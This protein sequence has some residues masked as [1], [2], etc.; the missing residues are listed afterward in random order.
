M[1][2]PAEQ[3]LLTDQRLTLI[4]CLPSDF[5]YLDDYQQHVVSQIQWDNEHPW[6]IR[7]KP[8]K[9]HMLDGILEESQELIH[10][11]DKVEPDYKRFGALLLLDELNGPAY[12]PGKVTPT[13]VKRHL[14]EFGDVAWYTANYLE[15]FGIKYAATIE[16]GLLDWQLKRA[17]SAATRGNDAHS[18]E[19]ERRVPAI[20]LMHHLNRLKVAA[21]RI[22]AMRRDERGLAEEELVI[23]AGGYTLA[24][25]LVLA[26][27]YG[28]T[29]QE[30]LGGNIDKVSKR[31]ADG[32]VFEKAGGDDR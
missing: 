28:I 21:M 22:E 18:D 27:R 32:T 29:Y 16:S 31:I 11:D 2:A 14:K 7:G 6:L 8:A 24:A 19:S 13:A 15:L 30:V 20:Y 5:S 25:V 9:R 12:G 3:S 17:A 1:A 4:E 23:A 26:N 10:D